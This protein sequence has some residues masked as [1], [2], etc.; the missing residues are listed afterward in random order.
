[1]NRIC[2]LTW[3][4][5]LSGPCDVTRRQWPLVTR[6][7]P[8]SHADLLIPWCEN[9]PASNTMW[10]KCYLSH[11]HPCSK[12]TELV[13]PVAH[14]NISCLALQ[15]KGDCNQRRCVQNE[16]HKVRPRIDVRILSENRSKPSSHIHVS[17]LHTNRS[18]FSLCALTMNT[19][20]HFI[21]PSRTPSTFQDLS[22]SQLYSEGK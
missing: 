6:R 12:R 13:K 21:S 18:L 7:T 9:I 22:H 8:S 19:Y 4:W 16:G 2:T 5:F 17:S 1:M 14:L 20:T 15:N 3:R 11:S 10:K